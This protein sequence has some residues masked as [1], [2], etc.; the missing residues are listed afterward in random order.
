MDLPYIYLQMN[1]KLAIR[2]RTGI[3]C[4]LFLFVFSCSDSTPPD[5]YGAIPSQAQ[6][7]WQQ[8]EYYMFVHFGPNTFTDKEWGDGKENPKV[9]NPT[10]LDCKQWAAT[11]KAAGMKAIIIT[12]KHHDG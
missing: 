10:A 1:H 3:C 12:A 2:L 8:T 9:F 11:A 6:M 7:D 5:P 4:L